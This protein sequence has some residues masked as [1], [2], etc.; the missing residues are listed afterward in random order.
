MPRWK[1]MC[2]LELQRGSGTG[3][4]YHRP[5]TF[6]GDMVKNVALDYVDIFGLCLPTD[7]AFQLRGGCT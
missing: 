7:S 3:H 1:S 5:G 2:H 4:R 6:Q